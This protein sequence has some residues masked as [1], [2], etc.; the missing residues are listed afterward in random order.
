MNIY[1]FIIQTLFLIIVIE[2]GSSLLIKDLNYS[3]LLNETYLNNY[4]YSNLAVISTNTTELNATLSTLINI[5]NFQLLDNYIQLLKE[6]K[7]E[8]NPYLN[9]LM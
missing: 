3:L 6:N 8:F 1:S 4:L 5:S 2:N 7:I 9:A